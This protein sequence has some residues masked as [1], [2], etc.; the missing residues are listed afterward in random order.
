MA[1]YKSDLHHCNCHRTSTPTEVSKF[2]RLYFT[3]T[4]F[5]EGY[6]VDDLK[7]GT[8]TMMWPDGFL[9]QGPWSEGLQ[10]GKGV[11]EDPQ[12]QR[13]ACEFEKGNQI[14]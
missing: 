6:F 9:Y 8:G 13:C 10:H 12:G 1:N 14:A 5:S 2:F 7:H 3:C 4:P 11:I